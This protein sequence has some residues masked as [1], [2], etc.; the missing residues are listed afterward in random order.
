PLRSLGLLALVFALIFALQVAA[1]LLPW[2]PLDPAWQWR[3]ATTLI[4]AAP[5]P[6][7]ALALLQ[8][9][10]LFVRQLTARARS[11]AELNSELQTLQGP[12]LGPA[13][14]A[15][16]LPLLKA[17]VNAVVDQAQLQIN[18]D[19]AALPPSTPATALPELLRNALASSLLALA[20]AAFAG[21]SGSE[22]SLLEETRL[23]LQRLH[24]IRPGRNRALSEADDIRQMHGE[25][26]EG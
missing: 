3:L 21:R 20:Y 2:Q 1:V 16:P 13:D 17:Q 4:N 22:L 6:L 12:V 9:S 19:R 24:P 8:I 18:R 26:E 5:L 23:R 7:L 14:L 11:T 10:V 15:N 25:Q